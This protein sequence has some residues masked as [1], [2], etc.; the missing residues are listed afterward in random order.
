MNTPCPA[1]V[2][3]QPGNIFL[4]SVQFRRS[5]MQRLQFPLYLM[6]CVMTAAC[7]SNPS[8][9]NDDSGSS[10]PTKTRLT[11]V[12]PLP[13]DGAV[14]TSRHSVYVIT[15]TNVPTSRADVTN[16]GFQCHSIA[17][18]ESTCVVDV[19][20]GEPVAL[21]VEEGLSFYSG[22]GTVGNLA[23]P[24]IWPAEFVSWSGD[25]VA[26]DQVETGM[27]RFEADAART[28]EARFRTIFP[29]TVHM[30]AESIETVYFEVTVQT[31]TLLT[32]PDR[33]LVSNATPTP[34]YGGNSTA[35][36]EWFFLKTGSSISIL[37]V[38][39]RDRGCVPGGG[40]GCS[41]FV[42]WT[43]DCNGSGPCM[44]TPK[45]GTQSVFAV[46]AW[47]L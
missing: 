16:K 36:V 4:L 5:T 19:P 9:N 43:G 21:V 47:R 32:V 18:E 23:P 39:D 3:M 37:A 27:L 28:I 35:A 11:I 26:S 30:N 20:R 31:P 34:S 40:V 46:T 2:R 17:D 44:L 38:D 24:D 7:G 33:E 10:D 41:E 6:L 12:I 15:G 8:G 45:P 1:W 29:I 25:F 42:N 14:N 22:R 13:T